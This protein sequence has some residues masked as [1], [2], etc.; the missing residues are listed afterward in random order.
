MLGRTV[1]IDRR[2]ELGEFLRSRPAGLNPARPGCCGLGADTAGRMR[3]A[4]WL[5]AAAVAATGAVAV[6]VVL[7]SSGGGRR[8]RWRTPRRSSPGP[9]RPELFA[10]SSQGSVVDQ[11]T[12]PGPMY[13]AADRDRR[14][15][16]RLRLPGRSGRDPAEE[17]GDAGRV[18]ARRAARPRFPSAPVRA[19]P[20]AA[21]WSSPTPGDRVSVN[22]SEVRGEADCG[23]VMSALAIED[24]RP[25]LTWG[26]SRRR[27]R[28]RAGRRTGGPRC[29]SCRRRPR[30]PDAHTPRE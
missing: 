8:G 30:R 18:P 29:R 9:T 22:D 10:Q 24:R 25:V 11:P 23:A 13:P 14:R 27:P 17:R 12:A 5:G 1:N 28:S 16:D 4:M 15:R 6:T 20:R 26:I 21:G 3:G 19:C 2:A 7:A